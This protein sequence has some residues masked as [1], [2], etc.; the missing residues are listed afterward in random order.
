MSLTTYDT[1]G[2]A[3]DSTYDA[4]MTKGPENTYSVSVISSV[5]TSKINT[6]SQIEKD[7]LFR[8]PS[9][10]KHGTTVWFRLYKAQFNSSGGVPLPEISVFSY[11]SA[12]Q[13]ERIE[14]PS[15]AL[16]SSPLNPRILQ[17]PGLLPPQKQGYPSI[18]FVHVVP[19]SIVKRS[20]TCFFLNFYLHFFIFTIV[21]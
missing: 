3:L 2:D 17:N 7:V 18:P 20:Y 9:S 21:R 10:E 5:H 12:G 19:L 11:S 16:L 1:L 14:C 15:T 6:S 13:E 4:Q 8:Q